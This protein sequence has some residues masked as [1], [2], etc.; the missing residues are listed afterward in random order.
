[1]NWADIP[2]FLHLFTPFLN[3]PLDISIPMYPMRRADEYGENYYYRDTRITVF[4]WLRNN[5][6]YDTDFKNE[7]TGTTLIMN[8]DILWLLLA[9]PLTYFMALPMKKML[10]AAKNDSREHVLI[11]LLI[12]NSI[13]HYGGFCLEKTQD[14]KQYAVHLVGILCDY[15]LCGSLFN[16]HFIGLVFKVNF[17]E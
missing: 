11:V 9:L 2:I 17:Q 16:T 4:T 3:W 1:M 6:E 14:Q 5:S 10:D 12:G 13:T 7:L 8:L 15:S